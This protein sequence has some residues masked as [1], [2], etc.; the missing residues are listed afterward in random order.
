MKRKVVSMVLCSILAIG[1]LT[2]CGNNGDGGGNTSAGNEAAEENA[3]PAQEAGQ[4]D[5]SQAD[6]AGQ[7]DK[8][9]GDKDAGG[10]IVAQAKERTAERTAVQSTW[11][12]PTTGP[13][14]A[15]DKNIVCV[16]AN[17]ENGVE[18]LWGESVAEAC[19]RIG[20][21]CT[22]LDGKGTTQGQTTAINQAIS[23]GVDAIITSADVEPLQAV[24]AEAK[25]AG[26][27]TVGI[28]GS[29]TIGPDENLN[30]IYNVTSS[31]T[32]IG[33]ALA[34]YVIADSDG[35][36][37][38]VILYDAQYAIAREKAEA[39]KERIE[40]CET[41]ELLDYVNSPLS[42]VPTNMP[43][44]ASS[45]ASGFEKPFYVISIADYYYDFVTPTLRNGGTSTEDVMLVG[46]DGTSS[47]YDRIRNNDYQVGTIP[48][49]ATLLGY[50]AVDELNRHFNG[51]ELVIYT[52]VT[53][54]VTADNIAEEGGDKDMYIPSN[55][56]ADEYA[57]I[58]GVE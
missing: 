25:D 33:Y 34:D 52:P 56:F 40:E 38:V 8:T 51:E 29:N 14:A 55:N 30:L 36:G 6:E 9:E 39:M 18:A 22:V 45:W 58:W 16:N 26:I 17:S 28:H 37:K 42:E 44:L 3:E 10:D 15:K 5:P 35:K 48:E 57:K 2:G 23:M 19:A 43:T 27:P 13:K 1:L 21:E 24:I 41:M 49:P 31:G 20:W 12:G 11:D 53:H 7:E 46:S 32:D 50:I 4:E 47:A 54:I